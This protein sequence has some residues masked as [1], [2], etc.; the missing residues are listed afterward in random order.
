MKPEKTITGI[1]P[2]LVRKSQLILDNRWAKVRLDECELPDGKVVPD[3]YYWEGNDFAQIFA[4]TSTND[5]VL[6]RQYK[7]AVKEIV[8]E[9]PAG[10]ID[11]NEE[12]LAAA[13]RELEEETGYTATEWVELGQL[14][15][16][17]AKATTRAS[18]FLAKD[19]QKTTD[20]KLDSTEEIEILIVTID[21]LLDLMSEGAIRDANSVATTLLAL[22]ALGRNP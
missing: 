17:S 10:L 1:R 8:T 13:K 14:N 18:A 21:E 2:W 22:R 9:L 7:H 15:V 19:V 4:L 16:S 6:T 5:V 11:L 3:Y 12:P 20:A